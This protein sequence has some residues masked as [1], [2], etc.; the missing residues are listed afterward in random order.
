MQFRTLVNDRTR[1]IPP[2]LGGLV[3]VLT[4]YS[5]ID[6]SLISYCFLYEYKLHAYV[7]D[8]FNPL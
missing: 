3:E 5:Q 2:F 8:I 1:V 7:Y 6:D 4:S